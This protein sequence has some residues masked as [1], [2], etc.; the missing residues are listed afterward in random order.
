MSRSDTTWLPLESNPEVSKINIFNSYKLKRHMARHIAI[1]AY[2]FNYW[3]I[4]R[5]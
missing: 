5:K 4:D 2:K 1:R 3:K